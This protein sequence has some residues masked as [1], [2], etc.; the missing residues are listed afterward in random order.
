MEMAK[1]EGINLNIDYNKKIY[2]QRKKRN[3]WIKK[4]AFWLF[5]VGLALTFS[6]INIILII[7]FFNILSNF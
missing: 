3:S 7:E 2:A 5:L 4:H 6:V 1:N